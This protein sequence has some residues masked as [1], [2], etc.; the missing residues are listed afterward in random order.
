MKVIELLLTV[1]IF[2]VSIIIHTST[3]INTIKSIR[4]YFF[5]DLR[6]SITLVCLITVLYHPAKF[7]KPNNSTPSKN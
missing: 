1:H 6:F 3:C 2:Q 7:P 4:L 5:I